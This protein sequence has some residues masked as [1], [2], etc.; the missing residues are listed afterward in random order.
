MPKLSGITVVERIR[1]LG[2]RVPILLTSGHSESEEVSRALACGASEFLAKPYTIAT[3][4]EA[5]H[6]VLDQADATTPV[7]VT[8]TAYDRRRHHMDGG[9]LRPSGG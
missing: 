4:T 3:L 7:A 2:S 6:R 1:E 5:L 9:I 8:R